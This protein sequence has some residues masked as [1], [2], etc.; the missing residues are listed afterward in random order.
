MSTAWRSDQTLGDS[1]THCCRLGAGEFNGHE[2]PEHLGYADFG[3][4][5]I[6]GLK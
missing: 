4:I 2:L 6:K 5:R 3:E 1:I